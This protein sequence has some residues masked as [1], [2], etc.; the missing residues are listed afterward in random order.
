MERVCIMIEVSDPKL[1]AY[2]IDKYRILENFSNDISEYFKLYRIERGDNVYEVN[3]HLDNFYFLVSGTLKVYFVLE[4]GK[5]ILLRFIKPLGL[6][7]DLEV[8]VDRIV[9]TTVNAVTDCFLIGIDIGKLKELTFDDPIFMRFI[10]NSLSLKLS[11]VSNAMAINLS[12]PL[13]NRFA[14]YLLS[15]SNFVDDRRVQEIKTFD[16][17]EIATMLGTSYR[18]LCRVIKDFSEIGYIEKKKSQII[19]KD[20]EALEKLSGGFYE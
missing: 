10:I 12:Y 9:K 6:A 19:I 18:H 3:S 11:A 14:G 16:L 20:F 17:R 13:E 2:Y 8:G 1:M 7:G 5:T 15:I 4:N